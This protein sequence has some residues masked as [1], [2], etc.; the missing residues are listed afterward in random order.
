M[1]SSMRAHLLGLSMIPPFGAAQLSMGEV[2]PRS[3]PMMDAAAFARMPPR[4]EFLHEGIRMFPE[5]IA[6]SRRTT[7]RPRLRRDCSD[8]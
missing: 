1:R 5:T 7:T 6:A 3:L 8:W 4:E 2:A